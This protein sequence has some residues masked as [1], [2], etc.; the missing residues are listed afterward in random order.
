MH[1]CTLQETTYR[2]L[3]GQVPSC[4]NVQLLSSATNNF[5]LVSCSA[6]VFFI[7]CFYL[8]FTTTSTL[9]T[10]FASRRFRSLRTATTTPLSQGHRQ[11]QPRGALI[12]TAHRP[13]RLLSM[14]IKYRR[15]NDMW[16]CICTTMRS[17]SEGRICWLATP[18]CGRTNRND[19][20]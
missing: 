5:P 8:D 9:M 1:A 12:K 10:P 16:Y 20:P 3:P 15:D 7:L 11:W 14:F 4:F 18:C 6:T 2:S 19:R 13:Q 17:K